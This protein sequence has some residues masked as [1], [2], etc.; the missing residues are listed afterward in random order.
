MLDLKDRVAQRM[1]LTTD[2]LA[3]YL[4]AVE[5][6]FKWNGIDYAMLVKIYGQPVEGEKRYSPAE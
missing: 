5:K 1:Q 3:L 4:R 2:G 6:A